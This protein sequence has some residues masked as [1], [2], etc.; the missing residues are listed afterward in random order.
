M[1]DVLG[2]SG[3]TAGSESDPATP[4]DKKICEDVL[5][6]APSEELILLIRVE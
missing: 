1:V 2:D 5:S 3:V 4:R 6:A